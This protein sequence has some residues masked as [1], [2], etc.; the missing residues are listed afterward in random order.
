[1]NADVVHGLLAIVVVAL[2]ATGS[3]AQP[4]P[5][6]APG[7][8]TGDGGG[9]YTGIASAPQA[10]LF[11]GA[12]EASIP[13]EAPPGR[14]GNT[15]ALVLTYSSSGGPSPYGYGWSL[16]LP[17]IARSTKH[18]VPRFDDTDVF[19]LAMPGGAVELEAVPGSTR[20]Y[21]PR[22]ESTFPRIGFQR[23]QNFWRV[24]DK[25]GTKFTFG[26]AATTR[27]GRGTS[28]DE[29]FSWLLERIEDPAG[30]LIEFEYKPDAEGGLS[31]GLPHVIRYG[32]N[33]TQGVSHF[34]EVRFEWSAPTF[35]TGPPVS[36]RSGFAERLDVLLASIETHTRGLR[37]RRYDFSH[38]VD[39]TTGDARLV[40]ATLTA[41]GAEPDGDV[42]L[43]S[44]VFIYGAPLLRD[45]PTGNTVL[46]AGFTIPEVGWLHYGRRTVLSGTVDLDGDGIPDHVRFDNGIPTT[47]LGNGR[48]FGQAV[49]WNWPSPPRVPDGPAWI[50]R[51][52]DAK[53]LESNVFDLDGDGFADMVDTRSECGAPLGSWCVWRGSATGFADDVTYW[54]APGTRLRGLT[55]SASRV[56]TDLIDVDAD[57][58]LDYVDTAGFDYQDAP[59]WLVYRNEGTG[60]ATSPRP[61][62]AP[63]PYLSR[64][65]GGALLYSMLDMNADGLPDMVAASGDAG[66]PQLLWEH[67]EAWYVFYNTGEGLDP[68]PVEWRVEGETTLPN[69]LSIGDEHGT[70]VDLMDITGDGRPDLVRQ[71]LPS[72]RERDRIPA[73]CNSNSCYRDQAP[74][75]A[76]A[77]G[78]CCHNMRVFVNTGSSFSDPVVWQ[79]PSAAP[80]GATEN[81]P[82]T[83]FVDCGRAWLYQYDLFDFNGD[84]LVDFVT[85]GAPGDEPFTWRVHL[86]P[87]TPGLHGEGPGSTR[88]R[89][90]LLV[91]MLNGIGGETLLGYT[92]ASEASD[93]VIP[94]PFWTVTARE[95][96]D[97]VYDS[98]PLRTTISYR[99]GAYDADERELRGFGMVWEV[100]PVGLTRV[101]EFEQDTRRK[102][103]LRSMSLLAR[104][105]CQATDP[106]D[107]DDPCSPWGFI[108]GSDEYGWSQQGPVL[109]ESETRTPY[110]N[111]TAVD[112]LR[113]VTRYE[114]DDFGNEI[115]RS[116]ET[117]LAATVSVETRY[118]Y[119]IDDRSNGMPD[120]YSVNKPLGIAVY[121]EGRTTPLLQREYEYD[122][123][124]AAKGVLVKASTC[125][126]W[127]DDACQTWSTRSFGHD[128]FG[129]VISAI[130]ATGQ[131]TTTVFDDL[132]VFAVQTVEADR[133]TT[134]ASHDPRT[135]KVT[136]TIA[137]NGVML[138][139]RFDGLGR[140]LATWGPGTS[141]EDPLGTNSYVPGA[142]SEGVP[143]MIAQRKGN[144]PLA[145]FFDGLGREV[146]RKTVTETAGQT[147]GVVAA[148]KR[149]DSRGQVR[150]E[151]I[152]F[153]AANT[154]V[155][156]LAETIDDAEGWIEHSYDNAGRRTESI[157]P[158][159]RRVKSDR[160]TPGILLSFDANIL[161]GED[162]GSVTIELFDGFNRRLQRD[163]CSRKPTAGRPYDC[164]NGSL[165]RSESWFHDGLGR[166]IENRVASL[167]QAAGD[168][169]TRIEY[170]G[171]G[172]R[173]G[174]SNGNAGTWAF[175]HDA[176]GRLLSVTPPDGRTM[177]SGHDRFGRLSR[178]D[179]P[180]I[181]TGYRYYSS[182]G[183]RG[184]VR[185]MQS[186]TANARSRHDFTYDERGRL[187]R[188]DWTISV[189]GDTPKRWANH[190][191]YDDLDRRVAVS[192]P[193][194]REHGGAIT[195]SFNAYGQPVSVRSADQIYVADAEYDL[196]GRLLTIEYG[197][198]L[199]ERLQYDPWDNASRRNGQLRCSRTTLTAM[200]GSACDNAA[201]DVEALWY[202]SYDANGNLTSV[203]D[204]AHSPADRA[205][206]ARSYSYDSLGRLAQVT[207]GDGTV[208]PFDFDALDN[209]TRNGDSTLLFADEERPNQVSQVLLRG[210]ASIV[211]HDLNG[212]RIRN[213][214]TT[215]H[216]DGLQRL[217]SVRS[218]SGLLASFGYEDTGARIFR[219]DAILDEFRYEFGGAAAIDDDVIERNVSFGNRLVAVTRIGRDGWQTLF[220]H[221]DHQATPRLLTDENGRVVQRSRFSAYGRRRAT[222]DADGL[223]MAAPLTTFGYTGHAEEQA[224]GLT[225]FGARYYDAST[226]SFL[227]L[228]PEFQFTSPYA[229]SD[230]NPVLGRDADGRV[231][232]LTAIEIVAILVG[233]AT[234][235]DTLVSTG[236][237]GQSLTAGVTAGVTVLV[238]N[239]L[240]A[241][242]IKPAAGSNVWFQQATA[243]ATQGFQV[244]Q[245]LEAIEDGRFASG[246][247]TAG[248]TAA[249]LIG[250]ETGNDPG[251]GT[252]DAERYARHG[253]VDRGVIDGKRT[254]DVSGICATRPGCV[255]NFFTALRE[256]LRILFNGEGGCVGGCAEVKS[257]T[258]EAG[259]GGDSVRLRC[260]SF[261]AIKCLRALQDLSREARTDSKA[262]TLLEKVSAELSGAPILRPQT[263]K[264]VTY[265]V[266][267]FDPV[268]WVGTAYTIPFR[269]DVVLGRNW[270]VPAPLLVH[271]D[272]M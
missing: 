128:P 138:H 82:F 237:L 86:H 100:D 148:L 176:D 119:R 240:S 129:N 63:F 197:N 72:D 216:Y 226:G 127:H 121:E 154:D 130:S 42:R 164:P 208:E 69:F 188:E 62:R 207:Y 73:T 223:E 165:Q 191:E 11:T 112:A 66:S 155:E 134:K 65:S 244:G 23:T 205:Y 16:P 115:L 28:P 81:C 7:S 195:T 232:E 268:T 32:A 253:I 110:S 182:G 132:G 189:G 250:I 215:Y 199:S 102:G 204:L 92:A 262:A 79:Y 211:T 67:T 234:F 200:S 90:H 13:I 75:I 87:S 143:R 186:R 89:P 133:G 131:A 74:S 150:R 55:R 254:I 17:R 34:A 31:S 202:R 12:A 4:T 84:G 263:V 118:Q 266:N 105:T 38:E 124:A 152:P 225:Y 171:L 30:N 271:H 146:A 52:D 94:F 272:S 49:E 142:V 177:T 88:T 251:P 71:S 114:Y 257:I 140:L 36:F 96:R 236:N 97:S 1:M 219:Y 187:I 144:A 233:T 159:G 40:G 68:V 228:D 158:D 54:R 26:T 3:A 259:A 41:Y 80:R 196:H 5:G 45:W 270:W 203:D 229:Y 39:S 160:T 25:G 258:G 120:T 20:A 181:R 249:S 56:T 190:Y 139:S 44:T 6:N 194:A 83:S 24:V 57:G 91:A 122:W 2:A 243:V 59:R 238:T 231:W 162:P 37:A 93:S 99:G 125:V 109:L 141:S 64:T 248:L 242:M 174:V 51:T 111:A 106:Q 135:G 192:H 47:R 175:E 224:A 50:R 198:G 107:P 167:G 265:P 53:Q 255:S 78:Y 168:A 264:G 180:G 147:V 184:K 123:K 46:A 101:R 193:T 156:D 95:V 210:Q 227:S 267:L 85:Q 235:V 117:P 116:A 33:A 108:L 183:G 212:R 8:Q 98:P 18:G 214:E 161:A 27:T 149:Y 70:L 157:F 48:G 213:G 9:G 163:T 206:D 217:T 22:I 241:T 153:Q 221:P 245:A 14:S 222:F 201:G 209:L 172:N 169:I 76:V 126:R 60:F 260:N 10:N 103:R 166:L 218:G 104:P 246:I 178:R 220:V 19:V 15:P 77:P 252:T 113:T 256:N 247:V 185:R 29:T 239:Q 261:G 173:A 269:S 230:G 179:A 145:T 21:R 170:D 137:P 58:R 136:Q 35:P 61:F 151:S 43:P